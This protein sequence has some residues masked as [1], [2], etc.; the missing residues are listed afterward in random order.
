MT[1]SFVNG[2]CTSEFTRI[3]TYTATDG[4][5]LTTQ[6]TQTVQVIDEIDPVLN[7]P[8][9]AVF[10][11]EVGPT[12]TPA[13]ASDACNGPLAVTEGEQVIEQGDCPGEYTVYRT[14]ST[15]DL[16]G[17]TA[18][19][20]QTI[21]VRDQTPPTVALP[22]DVVLP[23]GSEF[24]YPAASATDNCTAEEDITIAVFNSLPPTS[25]PEE[26]ILERRFWPQTCAGTQRLRSK[27]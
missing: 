20:A 17:N 9:N 4:C 23:C 15:E 3:R 5:G 8:S 10:S 16:C 6:H 25:C 2:D 14:F 11:C 12:F 22:A 27:P 1:E 24:V 7:A 21:Y 19:G 13:T 18:T 26:Y